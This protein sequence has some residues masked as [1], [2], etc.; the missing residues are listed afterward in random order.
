MP[1]RTREYFHFCSQPVSGE[2]TQP[3][4]GATGPHADVFQTEAKGTL[5]PAAGTNEVSL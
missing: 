1:K 5:L 4:F 2:S 3:E